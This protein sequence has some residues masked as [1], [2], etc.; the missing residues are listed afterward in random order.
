MTKIRKCNPAVFVLW[1]LTTFLQLGRKCSSLTNTTLWSCQRNTVIMRQSTISLTTML[2]CDT[3][4]SHQACLLSDALTPLTRGVGR[5][6][7]RGEGA[8]RSC[9]LNGAWENSTSNEIALPP[10]AKFIA[11]TAC[12]V[13]NWSLQ[14]TQGGRA[15]C[16]RAWHPPGSGA[17]SWHL[18]LSHT[19]PCLLSRSGAVFESRPWQSSASQW[20][21]NPL[22]VHAI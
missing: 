3:R 1:Q 18:V 5:G 10:S 20:L 21:H 6:G 4:L 11:V 7:R 14:P 13:R 16:Y 19:L 17:H 15:S 12:P 2:T 22:Q 9:R 8:V